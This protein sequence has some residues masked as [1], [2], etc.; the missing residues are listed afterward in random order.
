MVILELGS[1]SS[2][3]PGQRPPHSATLPQF[4][5]DSSPGSVLSARSGPGDSGLPQEPKQPGPLLLEDSLLLPQR[6]PSPLAED[7]VAPSS[8]QEPQAR[9]LYFSSL[10]RV[11]NFWSPRDNGMAVSS[12]TLQGHWGRGLQR[13]AE[14]LGSGWLRGGR[15]RILGFRAGCSHRRGT[16]AVPGAPLAPTQPR[17]RAS[18]AAAGRAPR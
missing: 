6:P 3:P 4:C 8:S 5:A 18:L 13:V 7:L 12:G 16:W 2:A 1:H 10:L 15:F 9:R 14:T 11:L 17:P